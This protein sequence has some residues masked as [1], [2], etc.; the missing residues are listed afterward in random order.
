M[1]IVGQKSQKFLGLFAIYRF[2]HARR[3]VR[4]SPFDNG[5]CFREFFTDKNDQNFREM[6]CISKLH[7]K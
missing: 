7:V 3:G 2:N 6:A 5:G 1:W 4:M